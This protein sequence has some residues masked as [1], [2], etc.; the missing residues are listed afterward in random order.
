MTLVRWSK[1]VGSNQRTYARVVLWALVLGGLYLTGL[2]S[3]LFFHTLA[4]VFS[5]AV[6]LAIFMLVWNVRRSLGNNY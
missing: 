5:V 3:F 6:A 1:W 4:E 2:Y